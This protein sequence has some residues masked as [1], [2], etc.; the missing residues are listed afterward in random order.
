LLRHGRGLH[1]STVSS[2]EALIKK[3]ASIVFVEYASEEDQATE[4]AR[5]L[6]ARAGDKAESSFAE[7]QKLV[8]AGDYKPIV[9]GFLSNADIVSALAEKDAEPAYLLALSLLKKFSEEELHNAV[10]QFV[11]VVSASVDDK[12]QFRLQ[13]LNHAF[14]AV[15]PIARCR[16]FKA[17]LE[18]SFAIKSD[19]VLQTDVE[20]LSKTWNRIEVR[21]VY[22]LLR[23]G[24][25][26]KN[27]LSE[28]HEW[29]QK[30][31]RLFTDASD[32]A[33][34]S[35]TDEGVR[36]IVDAINLPGLYSFDTLHDLLPIQ[37][38]ESERPAVW[39]LLQVFVSGTLEDFR[40]FS[41]NDLEQ[42]RNAGLNEA[43]AVSKLRSLTLATLG[44]QGQQVAYAALAKALQVDETEVENFVINA[45]ADGTIDA[46]ID[47]LRRSITVSRG[48]Q[49][50]FSRAQWVELGEKLESWRSNIKLLMQ[51]LDSVKDQKNLAASLASQH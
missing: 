13:L 31:F 7:Y 6:S 24:E 51:A 3:M 11:S 12:P 43:F 21:D 46:R 30:Y 29:T 49:R 37:R 8:E 22:K 47:Q 38:L 17:I 5:L 27:R 39:R 45:I 14:N 50:Q 4:L 33:L 10:A 15:P 44:S 32:P 36:G 34:A 1:R 35:L 25:R 19:A 18:Y 40:A 23:D 9:R 42:F 2:S 20:R 26:A 28:A 41:P 48:V 16:V